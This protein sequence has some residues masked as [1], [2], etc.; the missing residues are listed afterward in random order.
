M[1]ALMIGAGVLITIAVIA[2]SMY[3]L[4]RG[5]DMSNQADKELTRTADQL[6][7][8]KYSPYDGSNVSG[9]SVVSAVKSF[10]DMEGDL[11]ISITTGVHS[12]TQY[13]SSGTIS[14]DSVT[15][16]LTALSTTTADIAD[17]K[18]SANVEYVNPSGEFAAS[19]AYD[20]NGVVRAIVFTQN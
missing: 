16:T 10:R 14:G 20:A 4:G 19:L 8:S 11:I 2:M 5:Q 17:I 7:N 3:F 13:L 18:D 9:S 12:A 15:T 1:K 6:T